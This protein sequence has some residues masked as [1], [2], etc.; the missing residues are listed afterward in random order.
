MIGK[1]A[2]KKKKGNILER[3][4]L[5]FDRL[6]KADYCQVLAILLSVHIECIRHLCLI[7]PDNSCNWKISLMWIHIF[8]SKDG[9]KNYSWTFETA[10][11]FWNFTLKKFKTCLHNAKTPAKRISYTA[12]KKYFTGSLKC[13]VWFSKFVSEYVRYFQTPPQW[14]FSNKQRNKTKETKLYKHIWKGYF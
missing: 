12:F 8:P 5:N 7:T 4:S 13:S 9:Q 1:A 14:I 2:G 11:T 3:W 6:L 10:W